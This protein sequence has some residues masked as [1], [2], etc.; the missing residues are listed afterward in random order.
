[1]SSESSHCSGRTAAMMRVRPPSAGAAG[2]TLIELMIV[3]AVVG[4][5]AVI[6]YPSY[7]DYIQRAKRAEAKALLLELEQRLGRFYFDRQRYPADLKELGYASSG[8]I[9]AE[10]N[11]SGAVSV[12]PSGDLTTSYLVTATPN[13][14]HDD[15]DCG[16]LTLNSRGTHGASKAGLAEGGELAGEDAERIARECWR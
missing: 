5:L 11:Y 15:P 13:P 9:S 14:P 1:M 3:V 8:A 12:G 6:A 16:A 4:I 7:Q 10:G 2:V